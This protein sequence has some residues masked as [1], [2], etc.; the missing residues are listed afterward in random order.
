MKG[1]KEGRKEAR[2]EGNMQILFTEVCQPIINDLAAWV[3]GDA[4]GLFI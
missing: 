2:K 3:L 4:D 1:R